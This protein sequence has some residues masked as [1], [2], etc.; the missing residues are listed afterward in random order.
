M[1][2]RTA[3]GEHRFYRHPGGT[4]RNSVRIRTGDGAIKIDVRGDGAYVVAPGSVHQT[5]V[6]YE[7]VGLWPP[8]A[9]LPMFDPSWLEL[10]NPDESHRQ[11]APSATGA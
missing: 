2:T 7:R 11:A 3:K 5:G 8:V 9:E 6:V 10:E 4:V 1:A